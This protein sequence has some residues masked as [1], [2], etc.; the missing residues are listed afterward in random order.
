M[1]GL[2]R[3]LQQNSHRQRSSAARPRPFFPR[4]VHALPWWGRS[5]YGRSG[6]MVSN[7][8]QTN[9]SLIDKPFAK[10]LAEYK[11]LLGVSLDGPENIH[12]HYRKLPGGQGTFKRVMKGIDNLRENNVEFNI[13]VLVNDFNISKVREIY[14]F[15]VKNGFYF[16]QYIPCIEFDDEGKLEQFS[17]NGEQWGNFLIELFNQWYPRDI[18]KVSIRFLICGM[19][20]VNNADNPSISGLISSTF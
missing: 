10:H 12:D 5:S 4:H 15:L 20:V 9:A 18:H 2:P 17:I 7:G 6:S 19:V 16:H 8:L 13:L 1:S 3:R 11:F 14:D